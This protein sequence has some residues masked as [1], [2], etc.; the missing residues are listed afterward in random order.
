MKANRS[1][2]GQVS[3]HGMGSTSCPKAI[4]PVTHVPGLFC[5]LCPRPGPPFRTSPQKRKAR[6]EPALGAEP[7]SG[8]ASSDR[9]L[10]AAKQLAQAAVAVL[11]E[12]PHAPAR[13]EAV[14]EPAQ[15]AQ[16]QPVGDPVLHPGAALPL[17]AFREPVAVLP[18]RERPA[19]LRVHEA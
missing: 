12:R 19:D 15:R 6:A 2:M 16:G 14:D 10:L 17:R 7:S 8:A 1:S 5:N 9:R 4:A 3:F 18:A 11:E 13:A